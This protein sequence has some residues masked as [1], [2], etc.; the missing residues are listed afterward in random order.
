MKT[1][2]CLICARPVDFPLSLDTVRACCTT[3][4]ME[5]ATKP[6]RYFPRDE[7]MPLTLAPEEDQP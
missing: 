7:Q 5:R 3:C 1:L 6:G 2:P 4:T